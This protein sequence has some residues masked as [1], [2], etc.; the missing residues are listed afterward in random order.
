MPSLFPDAFDSNDNLYQ[1]ADAL[2]VRLAEDYNP[3]DTSI[4]VL[5]DETTMRRF[6]TT[7]VIT[8]TDQCAPVDERAISFSYTSR[9]LTTFD[10][11]I[12][13]SGFTDN[14]KPKN[15]TSVTQN[16][17][18]DHHNV[19]KDA[20]ININ[21]AIFSLVVNALVSA[22]SPLTRATPTTPTNPSGS[23]S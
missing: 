15:L 22:V 6:S 10:G 21:V 7:G 16:V 11:L 4:T 12:L 1:V 13:L 9:T 20:I 2:R 19:I 14:A 17:M 5:G 18:A 8:L 23:R 3:G